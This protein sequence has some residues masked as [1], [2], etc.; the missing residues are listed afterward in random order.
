MRRACGGCCHPGVFR[1]SRQLAFRRGVRQHRRYRQ[2]QHALLHT[3]DQSMQSRGQPPV[4]VA[5]EQNPFLAERLLEHLVL[6]ASVL[7]GLLPNQVVEDRRP[8]LC[9]RPPRVTLAFG[10]VSASETLRA[11]AAEAAS[12]M[13]ASNAGV[14]VLGPST[15]LQADRAG[16]SI[17]F[18]KWGTNSS[19]PWDSSS[20]CRI[21][22]SVSCS[23]IQ[24][25]IRLRW[26]ATI[27]QAF[28]LQPARV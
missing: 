18:S 21:C 5:V 28:A 10:G 2:P 14:T 1:M 9:Q 24:P 17:H 26:A 19:G 11:G 12:A 6:R 25:A 20:F 15:P 16:R 13:P 27:G 23:S 7:D 8:H 3:P 22:R 4:P